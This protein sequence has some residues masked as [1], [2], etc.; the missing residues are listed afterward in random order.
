MPQLIMSDK[1]TISQNIY[2]VKN[3]FKNNF[4]ENSPKGLNTY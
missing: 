4:S 3:R 2:Q 1:L